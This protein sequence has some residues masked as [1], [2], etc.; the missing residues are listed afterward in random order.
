MQGSCTRRFVIAGTRRH[1]INGAVVAQEVKE[2]QVFAEYIRVE[3]RQAIL[4]A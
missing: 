1:S 2:L 4:M 3:K